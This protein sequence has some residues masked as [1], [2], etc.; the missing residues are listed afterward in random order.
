MCYFIS[1]DILLNSH[2]IT[3]LMDYSVMNIKINDNSIKV[4]SDITIKKLLSVNLL[5]MEK[6]DC[7]IKV[8]N[9]NISLKNYNNNLY[10]GDNVTLKIEKRKSINLGLLRGA[11]S[12]F[13]KA[14]NRIKN[15]NFA[16]VKILIYKWSSPYFSLKTNSKKGVFF[17]PNKTTLG[18][19]QSILSS[20]P[21]TIEWIDSFHKT[22]VLLDIGAN[23]GTFTIYA[24]QLG[25]KVI[26]VEPLWSNYSVLC[27][28]ITINNLTENIFPLNL[29][30]NDKNNIEKLFISSS[31]AG[32]SHN[33]VDKSVV[34]SVMVDSNKFLNI[35]G[36]GN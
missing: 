5:R 1:I 35:M 21:D 16:F 22:D 36:G 7:S 9:N 11:V 3:T 13:Q 26:S 17:A 28:N 10:E 4:D 29:A 8:N 33:T 18:R 31:E 30:L 34:Q 14:I 23:V 2:V 25:N 27:E 15:F 19:F 12:V 32:S 6:F 20:E 24:G